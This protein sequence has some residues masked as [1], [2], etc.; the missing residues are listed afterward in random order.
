MFCGNSAHSASDFRMQKRII[1]IMTGKWLEIHA[2]NYLAIS[3]F[4]HFPPYIYF[5]SYVLSWKIEN[6]L[7]QTMRYITTVHDRHTIF[8]FLHQI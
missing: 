3:T 5:L 8:I 1:R 6:F 4:F 7:L 2:G